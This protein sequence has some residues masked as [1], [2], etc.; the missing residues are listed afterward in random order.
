MIELRPESRDGVAGTNVT[1]SFKKPWRNN[2]GA[3][4]N[5]ATP[6]IDEI[7]CLS[8]L[9]SRA[10]PLASPRGPGPT[11]A[12][13]DERTLTLAEGTPLKVILRDPWFSKDI[14]KAASPVQL[15]FEV[16]ADVNVE[17]ATVVRKGALGVGRFT[18]V[19]AATGFGKG[20]TMGF[21]IDHVTAVDGQSVS[22]VGATEGGKGGGVN[23]GAGSSF[24]VN[25]GAAGGVAGVL[26][27]MWTK[28]Y[29]ALLRAGTTFDVE[30]SG[31]QTIRVAK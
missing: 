3:G 7:D 1:I 11:D 22:V 19:K 16:A 10:D 25:Y 31:T 26:G 21:V 15:V 8:R 2:Y 12:P 24:F 17:D 5:A 4:K 28:G 14:A 20:A 6:L 18:Q 30:V 23:A 27:A 29:D 13:T 9:L